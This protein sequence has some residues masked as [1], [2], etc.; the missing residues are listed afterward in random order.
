MSGKDC[1]LHVW[2]TT[3]VTR[4]IAGI[5]ANVYLWPQ[6]WRKVSPY[7]L[8]LFFS[9]SCGKAADLQPCACVC[10]CVMRRMV[11][12]IK[13]ALFELTVTRLSLFWFR[14]SP[15]WIYL[16]ALY[17]E[18]RSR[19]FP[20]EGRCNLCNLEAKNGGMFF[21]R[22]VR[23]SDLSS[24]SCLIC[25]R[26]DW[27]QRNPGEK[28]KTRRWWLRD[29]RMSVGL[30]ESLQSLCEL[31]NLLPPHVSTAAQWGCPLFPQHAN[32]FTVCHANMP[33]LHRN[34]SLIRYLPYV[35][36]LMFGIC[37]KIKSLITK[38][39]NHRRYMWPKS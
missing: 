35:P 12:C 36:F 29:D 6:L 1:L 26:L 8:A 9:V 25:R 30:D 32:M 18:C 38:R 13:S 14:A 11:N 37:L 21:I 10:V 19:T 22:R 23:S 31:V 20:R 17:I 15:N 39:R 4:G 3:A 16:V 33:S 28:P 24:R 7:L 34:H 5:K 2:V 27:R